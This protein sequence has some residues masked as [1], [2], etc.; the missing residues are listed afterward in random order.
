M[1]DAMYAAMD[2]VVGELRSD[3]SADDELLLVSDHG[4]QEG[5][6]SEPAM[7]AATDA[8]LVKEIESVTEVPK[9]VGRELEGV[10][11]RPEGRVF[12]AEAGGDGE[13][14]RRQLE[15]LGYMD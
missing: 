10:D 13:A 12:G 3:L 2:E 4:L 6:H 7:I 8:R 9:A 11:H 1:Q 15:D 14:V 5:V